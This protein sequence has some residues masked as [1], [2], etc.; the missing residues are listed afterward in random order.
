MIRITIIDDDAMCIRKDIVPACLGTSRERNRN[1]T[2][3]IARL[4]YSNPTATGHPL[5]AATPVVAS[6]AK[7]GPRQDR[8]Q[9]GHERLEPAKQRE[10][11]VPQDGIFA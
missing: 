3:R 1:E 9:L 5:I 7:V 11:N 10:M 8:P 4:L 6:S 2:S